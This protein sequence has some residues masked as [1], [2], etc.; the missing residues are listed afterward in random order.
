MDSNEASEV[1]FSLS[2][3]EPFPEEQGAY[4]DPPPGGLPELPETKFHIGIDESGDSAVSML[5]AIDAPFLV[6][7]GAYVESSRLSEMEARLKSTTKAALAKHLD[8]RLD[9]LELHTG[10]ILGG[11]GRYAKVPTRTRREYLL[12]VVQLAE[13]F[14]VRFIVNGIHKPGVVLQLDEGDTVF[15]QAFRRMISSIARHAERCSNQLPISTFEV[16]A[17]QQPAEEVRSLNLY[18]SQM[19][20]FDIPILGEDEITLRYLCRK[21]EFLDSRSSAL[22][23]LADLAAFTVKRRMFRELGLLSGQKQIDAIALEIEE[24]LFSMFVS[25]SVWFPFDDVSMPSTAVSRS[26]LPMTTAFHVGGKSISLAHESS[27]QLR[28]KSTRR[29]VSRRMS[30]CLAPLAAPARRSPT[31]TD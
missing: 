26:R 1:L 10:P 18:L 3:L 23:Q 12:D 28:T 19:Y 6:L 29:A 15:Q 14:D 27:G 8:G 2:Q 17:D 24:R 22:V 13:E 31:N 20:D 30:T 11:K 21:V 7:A 5:H 9:L 16:L 25:D 4:P